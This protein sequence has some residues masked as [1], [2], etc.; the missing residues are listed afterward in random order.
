M[1][2]GKRVRRRPEVAKAPAAGASSPATGPMVRS[3]AG[4]NTLERM[5][6]RLSDRTDQRCGF[7]ALIGAAN[8]GKSTLI[9]A[10]VGSKVAIVS[11]KAQTTRS[12]LR[13]IAIAGPA[14]LILIDTPGIFAPRRQL[15]RAMVATAWAGAHDADIVGLIL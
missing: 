7:V 8:A 11:H 10:L 6:A 15:D 9:N 5:P 4:L 3:T 12:L 2:E 14:Q 1:V 13:G